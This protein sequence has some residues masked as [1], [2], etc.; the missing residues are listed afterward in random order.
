MCSLEFAL[1]VSPIYID[2]CADASQR[3]A[4]SVLR[5]SETEMNIAKPERCLATM[6]RNEHAG[7]KNMDASTPKLSQKPT[8]ID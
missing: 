6:N 7:K 8:S 1:V 3:E 5:Y 2:A 4:S